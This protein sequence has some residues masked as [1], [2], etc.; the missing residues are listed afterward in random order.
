MTD[1]YA[2][3][4]A[5]PVEELAASLT[6][7]AGTVTATVQDA[8][9]GL[10]TLGASLGVAG[11]MFGTTL[12][13]G[14]A[15]GNDTFGEQASAFQ[16]VLVPFGDQLATVVANYTDSAANQ[17]GLVPTTATSA[18][19]FA[20]EE[21]L[22]NAGIVVA[23]LTG[24]TAPQDLSA[25]LLESAVVGG[26]GALAEF[27]ESAPAVQVIVTSIADEISQSGI[28]QNLAGLAGETVPEQVVVLVEAVRDNLI[29]VTTALQTVPDLS[30]GAE[31]FDDFVDAVTDSLVNNGGVVQTAGAVVANVADKVT[32]TVAVQAI[33]AAENIVMNTVDSA[34]AAVESALDVPEA[35]AIALT[36]Q[37]PALPGEQ[38]T[39]A[40]NMATAP[41]RA[42]VVTGADGFT[43][44]FNGGVAQLQAGITG[45][46]NQFDTGFEAVTNGLITAFDTISTGISSFSI[47]TAPGMPAAPDL[48]VI[49]DRLSF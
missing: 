9:M 32:G 29:D 41:V 37:N 14:A 35:L 44:A 12:Q 7:S 28:P 1:N 15:A 49:T 38:L 19:Q 26:V 22:K 33:G 34:S 6:T 10:A 45:A 25:E 2:A 48:S 20:E 42:G 8:A 11:E 30:E 21:V 47:P 3:I 27:Q 23:E 39:A 4:V 16:D 43:D 31:S 13:D 46:P 24:S 18:A 17:G 36:E 40:Y 5:R